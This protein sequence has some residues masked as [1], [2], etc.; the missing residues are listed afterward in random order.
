MVDYPAALAH[1]LRRMITRGK[2]SKEMDSK[3]L[4]E[5]WKMVIIR[6]QGK[7]ST[8]DVCS[9]FKLRLVPP[10]FFTYISSF[11]SEWLLLQ[12]W[13]EWTEN[14]FI[15]LWMY[16]GPPGPLYST[17]SRC[18]QIEFDNCLSTLERQEQ[19][20]LIKAKR[21]DREVNH[22]VVWVVQEVWKD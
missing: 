16:E 3:S 13:D 9:S 4:A 15:G 17:T 22:L 2:L 21:N 19:K 11:V 20:N 18:K 7:I 1:G 10:F 6:W 12:I 5:L 14:P 8:H